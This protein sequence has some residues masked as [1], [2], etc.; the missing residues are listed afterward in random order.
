ML[1][2]NV[3][4]TPEQRLSIVAVEAGRVKSEAFASRMKILPSCITNKT[5]EY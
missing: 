2:R 5:I 4:R 3:A 1:Y